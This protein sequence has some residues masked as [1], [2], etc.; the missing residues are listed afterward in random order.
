MWVEFQLKGNFTRC[1]ANVFL[2]LVKIVSGLRLKNDVYWTELYRRDSQCFNEQCVLTWLYIWGKERWCQKKELHVGLSNWEC[3]SNS[4]F[5][6]AASFCSLD[7]YSVWCKGKGGGGAT[8]AGASICSSG[9]V[10]RN[11]I[12]CTVLIQFNVCYLCRASIR[13][14]VNPGSILTQV[15]HNYDDK[16]MFYNS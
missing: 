12:I 13:L 3:S 15:L 2:I 7:S 5:R 6:A 4:S 11:E 10:Q 16:I 9:C 14:L 1:T 8:V